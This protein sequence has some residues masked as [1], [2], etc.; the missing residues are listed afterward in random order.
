[1][2]CQTQP[3]HSCLAG[4]VPTAVVLQESGYGPPAPSLP[5]PVAKSVS[6]GSPEKKNRQHVYRERKMCFKELAR[7]VME[8]WLVQHLE[9]G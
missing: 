8:A 4:P 6:Q 3:P 2:G 7:A 1:M 5:S 9:M